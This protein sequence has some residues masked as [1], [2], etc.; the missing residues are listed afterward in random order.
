VNDNDV[1]DLLPNQKP[2]RA[3]F[4]DPVAILEKLLAAGDR[5]AAIEKGG[6]FFARI[7]R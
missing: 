3:R 1:A 4:D 5:A 2:G 7:W 6:R